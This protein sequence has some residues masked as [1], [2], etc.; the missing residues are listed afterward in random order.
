MKKWQPNTAQAGCASLSQWDS[1]NPPIASEYV[2][3]LYQQD[4]EDSDTKHFWD[5]FPSRVFLYV[6]TCLWF[7]I[8]AN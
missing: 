5:F 8:S 3:I 1:E 6:Q 7:E 2:Y 4:E